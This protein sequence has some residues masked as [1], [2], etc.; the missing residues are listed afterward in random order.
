MTWFPYRAALLSCGLPS[1]REAHA[2]Q[3]RASPNYICPAED[4]VTSLS[5]RWLL[6]KRGSDK[7]VFRRRP[8]FP[9]CCCKY[10]VQ[11]PYQNDTHIKTNPPS[12]EQWDRGPVF[13]NL[14]LHSL[15]FTRNREIT[16]TKLKENVKLSWHFTSEYL[17][18]MTEHSQFLVI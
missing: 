13:S 2:S 16:N 1:V 11:Y 14:W 12:M 10:H 7:L 4:R 8:R 17:Q 18:K 15:L 5:L 6:R 9:L 3:Q